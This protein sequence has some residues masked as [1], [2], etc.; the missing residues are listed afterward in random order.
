MG[1]A[2]Q[3]AFALNSLRASYGCVDWFPYDRY[4]PATSPGAAVTPDTPAL[5]GESGGDIAAKRGVAVKNA[6]HLWALVLAA[7]DGSRLRDLTIR[8]DGGPVP[9]QYCS[10]RGGP[11]LLEE[12]LHRAAKV[13]PPEHISL[14]VAAQ[15]R[16]WWSPAQWRLPASSLVVQ[17]RNRGTAIGILLQLLHVMRLDADAKLVLLPSDHFVADEQI[18]AEA[19]RSAESRVLSAPDQVILL[20]MPP[21]FP[22]ADLGYIC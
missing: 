5:T 19:I 1:N 12:T 2:M 8:A 20:G 16:R 21:S 10:L 3:E 9:K 18:L 7:G 15:H 4:V 17:P 6:A 13:A 14:I 22:D 11:S